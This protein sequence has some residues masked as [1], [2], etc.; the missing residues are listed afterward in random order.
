MQYWET[1]IPQYVYLSRTYNDAID[2]ESQIK[3]TKKVGFS[4]MDIEKIIYLS[5]S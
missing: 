1:K 3:K 5:T 4:Y 2:A